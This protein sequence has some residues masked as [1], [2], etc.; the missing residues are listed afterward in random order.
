ML[1][2]VLVTY[3]YGVSGAFWYGAGCSPMIVFFAYLGVICKDRIPEAHTVLEI[4]RIRYGSCYS[5]ID[6]TS[7]TAAGTTAHLSFTFLAVVN[8]LFNTIN[9]ILGASAV[10]SFLYATK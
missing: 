8:N 10:I 2:C 3:A 7:L 6:S 1:S 4:I 5:S 9:M